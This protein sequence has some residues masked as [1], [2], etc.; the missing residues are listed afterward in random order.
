MD[1]IDIRR[2]EL[3]DP[4]PEGATCAECGATEKE[5]NDHWDLMER[6]APEDYS[7]FAETESDGETYAYCPICEMVVF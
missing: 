2:H 6:Y 1:Y 7:G 4:N 5:W 3:H